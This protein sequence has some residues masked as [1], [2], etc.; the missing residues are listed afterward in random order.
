VSKGTGDADT[1]MK[2][3][4]IAMYRAKDR[5]RD[6]YK[7]YTRAMN[8]KAL[9]WLSLPVCAGGGGVRREMVGA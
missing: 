3:A 9:E 7:Y 1:L 8:A 5:G 2:N 4:D 6:N